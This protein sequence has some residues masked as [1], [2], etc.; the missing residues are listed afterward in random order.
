MRRSLLAVGF[1]L[2]LAAPAA[3][4]ET[5][6]HKLHDIAR[7]GGKLCMTSHE[8]FGES[9]PVASAKAG[10]TLA[11]IKWQ[12]F[13]ADEYGKV[14]GSYANAVGKKEKCVGAAPNMV[15]SVEARACRLAR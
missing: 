1:G 13:T 9:P 8:H 10:R 14:W 12:I 3:A 11:I 7:I 6:H 15:C 2:G 5:G 4:Q